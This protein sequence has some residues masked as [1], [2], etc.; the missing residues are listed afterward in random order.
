MPS[1][2]ITLDVDDQT[3]NAYERAS[4]QEKRKLRLLLKLRLQD[5]MLKPA[6][7]LNEVM[8]E[9]GEKARRHGLTEDE[10]ERLLGDT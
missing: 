4:E 3:A 7:P 1:K 5:L 10:L 8:D 9:I 6:R 2:S